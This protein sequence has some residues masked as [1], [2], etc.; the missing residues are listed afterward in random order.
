MG[1]VKEKIV[2]KLRGTGVYE[3]IGLENRLE[4]TVGDYI[5]ARNVED[6]ILE[7][8]INKNLTIKIT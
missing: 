4:P 8:K 2:L 3:V 7:A 1:A 5:V 6:L